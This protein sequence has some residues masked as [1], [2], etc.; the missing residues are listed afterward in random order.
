M[1]KGQRSQD[2]DGDSSGFIRGLVWFRGAFT[3]SQLL[4]AKE[5]GETGHLLK[6]DRRIARLG[7]SGRFDVTP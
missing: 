7:C 1:K 6:A 5:S 3:C 2:G 4:H